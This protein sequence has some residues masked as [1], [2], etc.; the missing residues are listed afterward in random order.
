MHPLSVSSVTSCSSPF[1]AG[2]EQEAA[3]GTEASAK[4][5]ASLSVLCL[6]CELLFQ[7]FSAGA[8]SCQWRFAGETVYHAPVD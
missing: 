1:S 6:L 7:S 2:F 5:A 3:E 4:V 8:V